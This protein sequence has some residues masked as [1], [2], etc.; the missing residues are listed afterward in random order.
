MVL[1]ARKFD[2]GCKSRAS[3]NNNNQYVPPRW[4]L[5]FA[6]HVVVPLEHTYMPYL[7]FNSATK[8]RKEKRKKKNKRKESSNHKQTSN[9]QPVS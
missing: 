7:I 2:V 6:P 1:F 3:Q 5:P 9:R 8:Q 4:P